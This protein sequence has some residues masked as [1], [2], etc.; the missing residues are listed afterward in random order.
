MK[1]NPNIFTMTDQFIFS[2]ISLDALGIF[3]QEHVRAG[4]NGAT[5][6]INPAKNEIVSLEEA[7]IITGKP[8]A[9]LYK[10]TMPK[11]RIN[12]PD[13]LPYF[14]DGKF[15]RFKR[16]ELEAWCVR[17]LKRPVD[18]SGDTSLILARSALRKR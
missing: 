6:P 8:K 3:I 12:D 17:R 13:P 16:S 7:E 5:I 2:P 4:M 11:F 14:K 10:K 9:A 1:I 15:L 18:I